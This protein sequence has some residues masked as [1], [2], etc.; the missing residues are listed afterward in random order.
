MFLL[1]EHKKHNIRKN[2]R[3]NQEDYSYLCYLDINPKGNFIRL[4]A[5]CQQLFLCFL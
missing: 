4:L 2:F 3:D 1:R 5:D